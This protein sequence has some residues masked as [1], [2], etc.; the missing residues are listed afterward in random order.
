[1]FHLL[2]TYLSCIPVGVVHLQ[3]WVVLLQVLYP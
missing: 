3:V 1:M 2:Q